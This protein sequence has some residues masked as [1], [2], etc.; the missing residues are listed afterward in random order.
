MENSHKQV[1][2]LGT[3]DPHFALLEALHHRRRHAA[4]AAAPLF[5]FD[6]LPS[7]YL[8]DILSFGLDEATSSPSHTG[9]YF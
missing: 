4:F 3:V 8:L 1:A 7:W 9:L 6:S 2:H 5:L